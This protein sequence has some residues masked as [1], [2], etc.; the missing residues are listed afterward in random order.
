MVWMCSVEKE[1]N[2]TD[3]H[4]DDSPAVLG[5]SL[6]LS[7]TCLQRWGSLQPCFGIITTLG[8]LLIGLDMAIW[9]RCSPNP[10]F[11]PFCYVI[12][13]VMSIW[14]ELVMGRQEERGRKR[15]RMIFP[16]C[17]QWRE[18]GRE[19]DEGNTKSRVEMREKMTTFRSLLPACFWSQC[20]TGS[21]IQP[22]NQIFV[23]TLLNFSRFCDSQPKHINSVS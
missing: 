9:L 11:R 18:Q 19:R 5:H 17:R 14:L 6:S 2:I 22:L 12:S 16:P 1:R 7:S 20:L 13:S 21:V 4:W 15:M 23:F 3:T 10:F 8:P